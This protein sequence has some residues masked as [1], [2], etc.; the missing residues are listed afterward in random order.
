MFPSV[1]YFV[2]NTK[3]ITD[4]ESNVTLTD[5]WLCVVFMIQQKISSV[6]TPKDSYA[7]SRVINLWK[8]SRLTAV[9]HISVIY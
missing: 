8:V 9:I 2:S 6:K 5:L 7:I 1:C 4:N 3:K